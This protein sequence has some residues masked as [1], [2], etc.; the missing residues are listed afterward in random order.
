MSDLGNAL[1]A[2]RSRS[3]FGALGEGFR[4]QDEGSRARLDRL[5]QLAETERQQRALENQEASQRAE[6]EYRQ[7]RLDVE[8][9][10]REAQAEQARALAEYYRQGGR[11]GGVQ[12]VTPALQLRAEQQANREAR[13][14]FPSPPSGMPASEATLAT[15]RENRQRYIDQRLPQLIESLRNS[16]QAP[17]PDVTAPPPA[18]A[19]VIDLRRTPGGPAPGSTTPR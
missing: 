2:S 5:R 11:G 15:I 16:G 19:A 13:E 7:R 3:L 10:L 18:P 6:A 8:S 12:G 1:L 14:R 4:A 9:P 17:A